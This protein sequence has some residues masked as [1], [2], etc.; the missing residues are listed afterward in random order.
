MEA[1]KQ[2]DSKCRAEV[3]AEPR[4]FGKFLRGEI[5]ADNLP[6]YK[7]YVKCVMNELNSLSHD[8]VYD[9]DEERQNIPPEILEEGHRIINKCKDTTGSDACDIAFNMHRC[10]HDADPELYRKV[11]HHWEERANA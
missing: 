2:V 3:G 11:L 1:A 4:Y 7:C 5:E 6:I 9:I 10:Y 8:G